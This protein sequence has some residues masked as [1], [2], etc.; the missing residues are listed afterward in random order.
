MLLLGGSGLQ[1][2]KNKNVADS[3]GFHTVPNRLKALA[4]P[5]RCPLTAD[6]FEVPLVKQGSGCKVGDSPTEP[7]GQYS[8]VG[9][10]SP[11]S[12]PKPP[13]L[14]AG[15]GPQMTRPFDLTLTSV[16]PKKQGEKSKVR[17]PV[18]A[19]SLVGIPETTKQ[20]TTLGKQTAGGCVEVRG[21]T[22]DSSDIQGKP[23]VEPSYEL[24]GEQWQQPGKKVSPTTP[25]V[26]TGNV[27]NPTYSTVKPGIPVEVNGGPTVEPS[28]ELV[29]Q[30]WQQPV[31]I[32]PAPP[33]PYGQAS[34]ARSNGVPHTEAK[35]GVKSQEDGEAANSVAGNNWGARLLTT[36]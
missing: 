12:P 31:H 20:T 22:G 4:G 21:K 10:T 15:A 5:K 11:S 2:E 1:P 30:Q 26:P 16:Q 34:D 19:Y 29:G 17:A 35:R 14:A 3:K 28:Y 33:A 8:L 25:S 23:S 24:V 36:S 18:G 27:N 32:S 9:A 7:S 6:V 13:N